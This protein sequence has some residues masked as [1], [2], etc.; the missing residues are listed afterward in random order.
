MD[1]V[2]AGYDE[3]RNHQRDDGDAMEQAISPSAAVEFVRLDRMFFQ[4]DRVQ[5]QGNFSRC[6]SRFGRKATCQ[7][8][9]LYSWRAVGIGSDGRKMGN[10]RIRRMPCA[11]LF[12]STGTYGGA[13]HSRSV[14]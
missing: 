4:R 11:R 6:V 9:G 2:E 12:E 10:V 1:G 13:I 8:Q 5:H 7:Y 3:R 14:F